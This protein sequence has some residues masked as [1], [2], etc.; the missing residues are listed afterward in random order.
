M[1]W[2][3]GRGEGGSGEGDL[4]RRLQ[5]GL[6]GQA[7]QQGCEGPLAAHLR[8]LSRDSEPEG[9]HRVSDLEKGDEDGGGPAKSWTAVLL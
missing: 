5:G 2:R 7:A 1:S 4:K 3:A 8:T 6:S 9:Q